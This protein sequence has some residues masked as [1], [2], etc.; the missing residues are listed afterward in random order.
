MLLC[1]MGRDEE[2]RNQEIS[3]RFDSASET[4]WLSHDWNL[5]P[6]PRDIKQ[7]VMVGVMSSLAVVGF[8]LLMWFARDEDRWKYNMRSLY[9][10]YKE[11]VAELEMLEHCDSAWC[12]RQKPK[13]S[14]KKEQAWKALCEAKNSEQYIRFLQ[15]DNLPYQGCEQK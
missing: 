11:A 8:S 14:E 5:Q 13:V 3:D 9:A 7:Y 15:D 4:S 10:P 12:E 2:R 6:Y 1:E